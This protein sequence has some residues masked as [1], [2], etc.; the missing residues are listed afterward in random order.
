MYIAAA[1]PTEFTCKMTKSGRAAGRHQ[2]DGG[3]ITSLTG[4]DALRD[5]SYWVVECPEFTARFLLG[6]DDG[7]CTIDNVDAFIEL[8]D[9]C[10][11]SALLTTAAIDAVLGR[12]AK[13]GEAGGG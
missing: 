11:Y 7:E 4:V 13:T 3:G 9:G 5:G 12:W 1:D 2:S 10:I 8:P 6:A